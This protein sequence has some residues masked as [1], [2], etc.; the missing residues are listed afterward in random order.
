VLGRVAHAREDEDAR[1]GLREE[2]G[3]GV[4]AAFAAEVEVEEDHVR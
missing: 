2:V 3:D 4:H 1:L